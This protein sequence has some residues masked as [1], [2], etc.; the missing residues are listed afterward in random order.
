[1]SSYWWPLGRA[2]AAAPPSAEA[3]HVAEHANSASPPTAASPANP[4]TSGL[5]V[6]HLAQTAFHTSLESLLVEATKHQDLILLRDAVQGTRQR[7]YD[8]MSLLDTLCIACSLL[9]ERS[10]LSG[11]SRPRNANSATHAV[12]GG[13]AEES[14]KLLHS[15]NSVVSSPLCGAIGENTKLAAS[16]PVLPPAGSLGS[17]ASARHPLAPGPQH[18]PHQRHHAA[19]RRLL[20]ESIG[21]LGKLIA[22]GLVP[23]TL[24]V[25]QRVADLV[26][27]I[28]FLPP[29]TTAA[30]ATSVT[31]AR[32][33]TPDSARCAGGAV[34]RSP[35][36][37]S[38]TPSHSNVLPPHVGVAS[39][40]DAAMS[41]G[42][43]AGTAPATSV[44]L[45]S[46]VPVLVRLL[47]L[48]A[49]AASACPLGS[50]ALPE[51]Y[52]VLIVFYCGVEPQSMLEA[53][54]AASLTHRIHSVLTSLRDISGPASEGENNSSNGPSASSASAAHGSTLNGSDAPASST[55]ASPFTAQLQGIAFMK[56]ICRLMVGARTRWLHLSLQR[57]SS[58]SIKNIS[59]ASGGGVERSEEAATAP[60]RAPAPP[61]ANSASSSMAAITAGVVAAAAGAERQ[62]Q[63]QQNRTSPGASLTST[64]MMT[65]VAS[66]NYEASM[67]SFGS[68]FAA[69]GGG[70][71]GAMLDSLASSLSLATGGASAQPSAMEWVP[72]RLRV[73]LMQAVTLFF[74]EQG[75]ASAPPKTSPTK[76][77]ETASE[78]AP[79]SLNE[80]PLYAQ[81]LNDC[82]FSVALWGMHELGITVPMQPPPSLFVELVQQQQQQQHTAP[83]SSF[84]FSLEQFTCSQQLALATVSTNLA[85][86]SNSAQSLMEA[87][88]RLLQR[89][90]R[91]QAIRRST[92]LPVRADS[93]G[94]GADVQ[95]EKA[96]R[97]SQAAIAVLM[98]WRKTLT[99]SSL[100]WKLQQI[101]SPRTGAGTA[102]ATQSSVA[103][104][105]YVFDDG[106][107]QS[108]DDTVTCEYNSGSDVDSIEH[109]KGEAGDAQLGRHRSGPEGA[110][111]FSDA[112]SDHS[113]GS[114]AS[115]WR[116]R[117]AVSAAEHG[118]RFRHRLPPLT[119]AHPLAN[120]HSDTRYVGV[121]A[122]SY[123]GNS[124]GEMVGVESSLLEMP[125]LTR[126]VVSIA[127]LAMAYMPAVPRAASPQSSPPGTAQR[128]SANDSERAATSCSASLSEAPPHDIHALP[129]MGG[130][131]PG[132]TCTP[133]PPAP[134]LCVGASP[135]TAGQCLT[136][137]INFISAFGQ[138]LCQLTENHLKVV[139]EERQKREQVVQCCSA[140]FVDLHPYLLR[141]GAL[142]LRYLCYE[143]DVLPV[144]LKSIGYWVQVSCALQLAKQ[145]DTYLSLLVRAL[146]MPD[147]VVSHLIALSPPSASMS[148][149]C[150]VAAGGGAAVTGIT[151]AATNCTADVLEA[152]IALHNHYA[153]REPLVPSSVAAGG[154]RYTTAVGMSY[155]H[156]G[157]LTHLQRLSPSKSRMHDGPRV[158]ASASAG[159]AHSD[160]QEYHAVSPPSSAAAAAAATAAQR[161]PL[162][163]RSPAVQNIVVLG[164]CRLQHKLLIMKALHVIAN[165]LGAALDDGWELLACGTALTEPL[166]YALK[167]LLTWIEETSVE[168]EQQK[169]LLSDALHLRDALRSL[170]VSNT[171]HL[172][173]AQLHLFF[174]GLVNGTAS[175]SPST[176]EAKKATGFVLNG[177]SW[178]AGLGGEEAMDKTVGFPLEELYD[179]PEGTSPYTSAY[180]SLPQHDPQGCVDQWVLTSECLC[181]SL[182]AMLPFTEQHTGVMSEA[183]GVV[184]PVLP[185]PAERSMSNR[186]GGVLEEDGLSAQTVQLQRQ[187]SGSLMRILRLWEL[188]MG[189]CRYITDP[190]RLMYWGATLVA[191][192][193]A[194]RRVLLTFAG[195]AYPTSQGASSSE[196]PP[197]F[198]VLSQDETQV[199]ELKLTMVVGHVAAVAAHMCRSVARR[200]STVDRDEV[201]A[202]AMGSTNPNWS[203][204]DG[205][206]GSRYSRSAVSSN[207]RSSVT[208]AA[209]YQ[210]V[211]SAALVLTAGPFAGA[212]LIRAA[213]TL[214]AT[215]V[216]APP[217]TSLAGDAKP[218]SSSGSTKTA[219]PPSLLPFV[220]ADA[221]LSMAA[222]MY[223]LHR[224]VQAPS[225]LNAY[226]AAHYLDVGS[227]VSPVGSGNSGIA[228]ASLDPLEQLLA[229]PFALLNDVYQQ[230]TQRQRDFTALTQKGSG[231]DVSLRNGRAQGAVAL[232][233]PPSPSPAEQLGSTAPEMAAAAAVVA[234]TVPPLLLNAATLV[235]MDVVKV[236]QTY[237]EDIEGA[238]WEPILSFLQR[239]AAVVTVPAA[240][241]PGEQNAS[242]ARI[243]SGGVVMNGVQ[244]MGTN[245]SSSVSSAQTVESL[246][247]AFRALESIQHNHIPRLKVEGLHRLIV[248]IGAFTVHR[249]DGGVPGE[250]KLHIN[251]SA[252]Q[253]LWSTADYLA[254]FGGEGH[255]SSGNA[256]RESDLPAFTAASVG[257]DG[258]HAASNLEATSSG[259]GGIGG[260]VEAGVDLSP[261]QQQDR[262]WCT[263]L[264]QLRNG[265]LDDRQEIRQSAMQTLFA[266]VQTYGWRFSGA[267]WRCV[268]HDVLLPLIEVVSAATALCATPAPPSQ[269]APAAEF[270]VANTAGASVSTP[271]TPTGSAPTTAITQDASVQLL[272]KNFTEHPAQLEDVCVT[273]YDAGSRLFVT[274]YASM[275]AA[276][277]DSA[278]SPAEGQCAEQRIP[279][280][281]AT[282]GSTSPIAPASSGDRGDSREATRVL[283]A[284]LQL[285]GDVCVVARNTS[286]EKPAMA[287]VHA[288]HGLLVEMP[289]S[290]LHPF[291]VHLAWRALERLLFRGDRPGDYASGLP[292][293]GHTTADAKL[294]GTAASSLSVSSSAPFAHTE[295]KQCTLAVVAAMVAAVCDSFRLQRMMAMQAAA[296]APS[297]VPADVTYP[298]HD[299]SSAGINASTN[300]GVGGEA[301]DTQALASAG[302]SSRNYSTGLVGRFSSYLS[303]WS[304]KAGV[305]CTSN[306]QGAMATHDAQAVRSPAQYFTRLLIILQ[307]ASRCNA[308][309]SSYYFP[310]KP[311]TTLLEGVTA[312]WPTLTSREARMLWCEVLLPAFPSA[313]ELQRFILQDVTATAETSGDNNSSTSPHV[314]STP[315]PTAAALPRP[316]PTTLKEVMPPASHPSYLSLVLDTMRNLLT[317]HMGLEPTPGSAESPTA[318]GSVT[319]TRADED[320]KRLLF[321]APSTVHVTGTLLLLH[322]NSSA[323]VDKPSR[324]SGPSFFIPESF[325]QE[326]ADLLQFTLW[327]AAFSHARAAPGERENDGLHSNSSSSARGYALD[328]QRPSLAGADG[329]SPAGAAAEARCRREIVATLCR[330]FECLLA[331]TSTVLRSLDVSSSMS[332]R[333]SAAATPPPAPSSQQPQQQQQQSPSS[334][335]ATAPVAV[336]NTAHTTSIITTT[337]APP[338]VT[339]ALRSLDL[340][341]DTFGEI[342][343][344]M[345]GQYE[346]VA[347]ATE[348]IHTLSL[349]STA[350]GMALSRVAKRSLA[351][352]Q[353]WADTVGAAAPAYLTS[354]SESTD[355][356]ATEP[357]LVGHRVEERCPTQR[358]SSLD[359]L[360]SRS[361]LQCVL[362]AS[363]EARNRE[364]MKQ[365]VENPDDVSVSL[366]L[367]DTLHGM[368]PIAKGSLGATE[369]GGNEDGGSVAYAQELWSGVVPE[370]LQLV[371]CCSKDPKRTEASMAREKEVREALASVLSLLCEPRRQRSPHAATAARDSSNKNSSQGISCAPTA[372]QQLLRT[373]TT[374]SEHAMSII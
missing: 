307:A 11:D 330:V 164:V 41:V 206:I 70:G 232:S 97:L 170:C 198:A 21:D 93:N 350:E 357:C 80:S 337:I 235:L 245:I 44:Q 370:L 305:P 293:Q 333:L 289:G 352:L 16:M 103:A 185:M 55:V 90:Y 217:P 66:A 124:H 102:A 263:L 247:T 317:L 98:V 347:I 258:V 108:I 79:L 84:A 278:P 1:M 50:P 115:G 163:W 158:S 95:D 223:G 129:Q 149:P 64:P 40:S 274:H 4:A 200:L 268:L 239:T 310:S 255:A 368:L 288:L 165:A 348:T 240:E 320:W 112:D 117:N 273:L 214:F 188:E 17:A 334:L 249:V 61:K 209:S 234:K 176:L 229:S 81:C 285:C 219:S 144:A 99:C 246:N 147:P 3:S 177:H 315:T 128:R 203:T 192:A 366:L 92:R 57:I 292:Q 194:H 132:S 359:R 168:Q 86:T 322:L 329:S 152:L 69:P 270:S 74:K 110:C 250:R 134:P 139:G 224:A 12:A 161:S 301:E 306:G 318:A 37:R 10:G 127:K 39:V 197:P 316:P 212:P 324:A 138:Y 283:E 67:A 179:L 327:G 332:V 68:L 7:H 160:A 120:A 367:I 267:C 351:L 49:S 130:V 237:G 242:P 172:P 24:S 126:L 215:P 259:G 213:N 101:R 231:G 282:P 94:S 331:S 178:S 143:E 113:L 373:A 222:I 116:N 230:W 23:V 286:G 314:S 374:A 71:G 51:L 30:A 199:K 226:A 43:V 190:Q 364:I 122:A 341:V 345:M 220:Q 326:C 162:E 169:Q 88:E 53:T 104:S 210:A 193:A 216:G 244:P 15:S 60:S 290:G 299:S 233:P 65:A 27:E 276:L 328:A 156:L 91:K 33:H 136:E 180:A 32:T 167:R 171:C 182:L 202:A 73:L 189:I 280:C 107:R 135:K 111:M 42:G 354:C 45:I 5:D 294:G 204:R 85:S 252:V 109:G 137:A 281:W 262:L 29:G 121:E 186:D 304:S 253:L 20:L 184:S 26:R 2:A 76:A 58:S 175:L 238:A 228:V 54:C 46:D 340:M 183:T 125:P 142:C 254:A 356:G 8:P 151:T 325:L 118:T 52:G 131:H 56:D 72:V 201:S 308:V 358:R 187:R 313:Y 260:S 13:A 241:A 96:E 300:G 257:L 196:D 18:A 344:L 28:A 154:Y 248:C 295:A 321:M 205:L 275:Q 14:R 191:S 372:P 19:A 174:S 22:L 265:C 261:A 153:A 287:A 266:L 346:D 157:W 349:A 284:L 63:Q 159:S 6:R 311:Q 48:T 338:Y 105:D 365:Y 256:E 335:S 272:L 100:L 279:A 343:R 323:L 297:T 62:Q 87:H 236:V 361:Q 271:A 312:V 207:N 362:R 298:L 309:V 148:S 211:Q 339:A 140:L 243:G 360:T 269:Q 277:Q 141:C 353:R 47:Q 35:T 75:T 83:N 355:S 150:G 34:H 195:E 302:P 181:L 173:Y 78:G 218:P 82:I 336:P 221:S 146:R 342:M 155:W 38:S 363:M 77:D 369:D 25:G 166:L 225:N 59:A 291:G 36:T 371:A 119:F 89:L 251:L 114:P 227:A 145:R 319:N 31:T 303:A 208:V 296:A 9:A 264:L 133:H 106:H 123:E